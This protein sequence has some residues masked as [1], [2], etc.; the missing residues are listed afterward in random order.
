MS[1]APTTRR[2]PITAATT[3]PPATTRSTSAAASALTRCW[4]RPAERA[5]QA[6]SPGRGSSD[7]VAEVVAEQRHG[8]AADLDEARDR[9]R[10][11]L[12]LER[13]LVEVRRHD[14]RALGLVALVDDRVQLLEHP[15]GALL[16]PEVVD[17]EEVDLGQPPEELEVGLLARVGVVGAPDP[18]QQLR[19]RV[20]RD[21]VA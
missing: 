16:G 19:Q 4:V 12:L 3:S 8:V 1:A 2:S 9:A 15:V 11:D 21:R 10:A 7:A 13:G 20:D 17:V 5:R 18:R 14:D 6:A